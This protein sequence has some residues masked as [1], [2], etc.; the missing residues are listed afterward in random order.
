MQFKEVKEVQAV[1]EKSTQEIENELLKKHEEE[2]NDEQPQVE[3][4]K[5]EE[6]NTSPEL[7]EEDVLTYIGNR[8]GKEINS[9]DEF[10]S[11][12]Q[13]S[14]E[15]PEDVAAYFRYKKETGRGMDDYIKLNKDYNEVGEDELIMDYYRHTEE[16]LDDDDLGDL[17]DSKFGYDED[18]DEDSVIKKQKLAKKRELVQAKKFFK[19]Q[20]EQYKAPLESSMGSVSAETTEELG[21]YRQKAEEAKGAEEINQRR[22]DEFLS[23]TD[24]I[25]TN[26][27]KGFEFN[28]NDKAMTFKPAEASELRKSQET[29]LNFVNKYTDDN[30]FVTDA[31]GYHRALSVAMNPDKFAKFFYEQGKSDAVDDVSRKSKNIDMDMRRA[32][33]TTTKGGFKV[34]SL[35]QDSG[36]GLKIRSAK[37]I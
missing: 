10:V 21:R 19:E 7:S 23:E 34:K 33:E 35:N 13:E 28:V 18:F 30:H 37:R 27:F 32:P 1:E 12:R 25:F 17:I 16:G 22:V 14:E 5:V 36:R 15:L 29:I 11:E 3:E 4:A 9:I 8:Y 6:N 20:Q 31:E 2:F 26:E 24:K